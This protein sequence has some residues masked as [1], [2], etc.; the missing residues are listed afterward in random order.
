MTKYDKKFYVLFNSISVVS[1][2]RE[3]E[4][5]ITSPKPYKL[6]GLCNGIMVEN[7]FSSSIMTLYG[8]HT[9]H[10]S[11]CFQPDKTKS[12]H[13]HYGGGHTQH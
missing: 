9:L 11:L 6:F 4:N 12:I 2:R 1:G 3:G 10:K 5:D 7:I 13:M 8:Q